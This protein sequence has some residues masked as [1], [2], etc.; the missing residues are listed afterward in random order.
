MNL[1]LM[2][3]V[4]T[5]WNG[6]TVCNSTGQNNSIMWIEMWEH[7]VTEIRM[8]INYDKI[9]CLKHDKSNRIIL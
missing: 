7:S 6:V 1:W 5:I 8:I 9:M 3:N 4:Y 2:K